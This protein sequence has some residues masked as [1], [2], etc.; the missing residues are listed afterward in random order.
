MKKL[1]SALILAIFLFTATASAATW[2][3]IGTNTED[4]V[5]Y[6]DADSVLRDDSGFY[7]LRYAC[8]K[9]NSKKW[10]ESD[11]SISPTRR[12]YSVTRYEEHKEGKSKYTYWTYDYNLKGYSSTSMY[13]L[14]GRMLLQN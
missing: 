4:E 10:T 3:E 2:V 5:W 8:R 6:Y 9:P 14:L 13:E 7:S 1:L 12:L 11:V